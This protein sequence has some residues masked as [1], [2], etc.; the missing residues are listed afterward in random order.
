MIELNDNLFNIT[1]QDDSADKPISGHS[2]RS[3]IKNLILEHDLDNKTDELVREYDLGIVEHSE[4]IGAHVPRYKRVL[5]TRN[6]LNDEA[7]I[8]LGHTRKDN[9]RVCGMGIFTWIGCAIRAIVD[10]YNRAPFT[11]LTSGRLE[12]IC[13]SRGISDY[14]NYDAEGLVDL[15]MADIAIKRAAT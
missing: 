1:H 15:I 5:V 11:K 8:F 9:I 6:P 7:E 4:E 3:A 13:S 12:Q 10:G 2:L 14:S